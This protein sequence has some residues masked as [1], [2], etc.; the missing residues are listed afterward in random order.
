[1]WSVVALIIPHK[2]KSPALKTYRIVGN[3]RQSLVIVIVWNMKMALQ[4]IVKLVWKDLIIARQTGHTFS[5]ICIGLKVVGNLKRRRRQNIL[6][7][8]KLLCYW[9]ETIYVMIAARKALMNSG[10]DLCLILLAREC[11]IT[12]VIIMSWWE[13][14]IPRWQCSGS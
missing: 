4:D 12:R 8:Y 13:L 5:T 14:H 10:K 7:N 1:M 6:T 9:I 2:L 3:G 11:C